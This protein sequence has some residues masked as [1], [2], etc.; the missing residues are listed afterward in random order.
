ME[1]RVVSK[2]GKNT[3]SARWSSV[4]LGRIAEGNLTRRVSRKWNRHTTSGN[5]RDGTANGSLILI[6]LSTRGK[7]PEISLRNQKLIREFVI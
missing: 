3:R 5:E 6:R 1:C 2:R 4:S 7:F